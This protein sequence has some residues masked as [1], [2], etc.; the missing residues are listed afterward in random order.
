MQ[1]KVKDLSCIQAWGVVRRSRRQ[2]KLTKP[3]KLRIE[4]RNETGF[5]ERG[6]P[7]PHDACSSIRPVVQLA[8]SAV[9]APGWLA[10]RVVSSDR[11]AVDRGHAGSSFNELPFL[12]I[13]H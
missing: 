2:A 10:P 9:R 13:G 12:P 7:C 8:D 6:Q 3:V 4:L 5:P 11:V 1:N